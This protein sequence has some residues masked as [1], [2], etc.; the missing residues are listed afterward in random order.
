[1]AATNP[2][3]NSSRLAQ[4]PIDHVVAE[5]AAF[6]LS[7]V[8]ALGCSITE[9]SPMMQGVT[10]SLWRAA[11][12]H[13]LGSFPA[14]S[15]DEVVAIRDRIW[16]GEPTLRTHAVPLGEYLGN[17]ANLFLEVH[18]ESALPKLMDNL[19]RGSH[20]D[21]GPWSARARF[22]W[23]RLSFALPPDLVL[24][25][26]TNRDG[27]AAPG[28]VEELA[29]NL[30][31]MLR[32]RGFA[33]THL[34]LGCALDFPS[35]WIIAL[36]FLASPEMDEKTT[37][38]SPGAQMDE[39]SE[40]GGWLIRAAI[41]RYV[42]AAFLARP[43]PAAD[44]RASAFETF[45]AS[46]V[47]PRLTSRG[48][49][50]AQTLLLR[51]LSDLR[52]GR[53]VRLGAPFT[54][55]QELYR[56]LTMVHV[57]RLGDLHELPYRDPIA[58]LFPPLGERSATPEMRFVSAGRA[59]LQHHKD[60]LFATI[61]WQVVRIRALLYRHVV[62]RPMTPGLQWFIRFYG[63]MKKVAGSAPRR[64]LFQAAAHQCGAGK[65]LRSLEVRT[66]PDPD[67]SQLFKEVE[68][69]EAAAAA[70]QA[71]NPS[72]DGA[73]IEVGVVFHFSRE[74][75]DQAMRGMPD[76]HW[77][78][79]HTDP[80]PPFAA[81]RL[82]NPTGY[83]FARFYQKKRKEAVSLARLLLD[84]P[85]SLK[86][87][88][89]LDLCTDE[90]GVPIWVFVPLIRYVREAGQ[91]ASAYLRAALGLSVPPLRTT[92][93]VGED[94]VHLLTG[95]RHLHE[96]GLHRGLNLGQGDRIGHGLAMGIDPRGWARRAGR[97][98]MTR[99]DR[100]FDLAWEWDW[101]ASEGAHPP[102]GRHPVVEREIARLSKEMFGQSYSSHELITLLDQL[103]DDACLRWAGFP[104]G[105]PPADW[106]HSDLAEGDKLFLS[107][108]LDPGVF[109]RGRTIEW[110]DPA[111]EGEVLAEIQ[112]RIRRKYG[113]Y[114]IAVEVNPTSNLLIGDLQDLD[115]HPLWRLA[116]PGAGLDVPPV[117]VCIGSDDP[118]TFGTNLR[119]EYQFLHDA[120]TLAGLSDQEAR[121][122]LERTRANGLDARFTLA[123]RH[124]GQSDRI[125]D[126][127]R[128]RDLKRVGFG[129]PMK[130]LL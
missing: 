19:R 38:R 104:N 118:L 65:G 36:R 53:L 81:K 29:P 77:F 108:L 113:E 60:A 120:L 80:R 28:F 21:P 101:Y 11:E 7:S 74:R 40:L 42:L 69:I 123:R 68:T 93:H 23:R 1:M 12:R 41:A 94:F 52:Q 127:T 16:F 24:A 125:S 87:V 73:P 27:T 55:L 76:A 109:L 32:D 114:G 18:G 83:R 13:A 26:V 86:I 35:F 128:I 14:F 34:H 75:S 95:L 72:P 30:D 78:A 102:G 115:N 88:R 50:A 98:P 117:S 96:A 112:D 2:G 49:L 57:G 70:L 122:W 99:E 48:G 56:Q 66:S 10:A 43:M 67:R 39:G 47:A 5:V 105:P 85:L 46:V 33:E 89:G 25:A 129:R 3:T 9:L 64:T 79:S 17:L 90:Q 121:L 62:Q 22:A 8:E 107:Y 54:R 61:F 58:R 20:L 59:Y 126:A 6:P 45:V 119:Q 44:G 110:V 92:V 91:L 51:V 84:Y 116:P 97:I 106:R 71:T 4:I 31:R 130:D 111:G 82:G 100:L 124:P 63:R 37:F 15:V 103:H